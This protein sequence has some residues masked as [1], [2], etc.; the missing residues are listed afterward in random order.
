MIYYCTDH[1]NLTKFIPVILEQEEI[2]IIIK[3]MWSDNKSGCKQTPGQLDF[4]ETTSVKLHVQWEIS[5]I[6]PL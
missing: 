6:F 3:S 2:F 1:I 5:V 4:G